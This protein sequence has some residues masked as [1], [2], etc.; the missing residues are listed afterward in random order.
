MLCGLRFLDND[1]RRKCELG[2]GTYVEGHLYP[3]ASTA[4]GGMANNIHSFNPP[5]IKVVPEVLEG[6]TVAAPSPAAFSPAG[7][8]RR[9]RRRPEEI[10]RRYRCGWNG[11]EKA[12]GSLG[13]LNDH[14]QSQGHGAKRLPSGMPTLP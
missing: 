1:I 14:V 4:S 9:P 2:T 5:S 8:Q 6:C 7:K 11:C 10:D 12:Y 13:N 3:P